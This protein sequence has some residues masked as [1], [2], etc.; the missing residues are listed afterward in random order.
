MAAVTLLHRIVFLYN[1][2]L[3][4][5]NVDLNDKPQNGRIS[6]VRKK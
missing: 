4:M 3:D 1:N 2:Y 6:C 5:N